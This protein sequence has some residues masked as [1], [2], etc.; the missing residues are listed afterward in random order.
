[1]VARAPIPPSTRSLPAPRTSAS[2]TD[3]PPPSSRHVT[4]AGGLRRVLAA[5]VSVTLGA[6]IAQ[7][8]DEWHP[9]SWPV[10][11]THCM[12]P[13]SDRTTAFRSTVVYNLGQ[14]G[15]D[16]RW[17][18]RTAIPTLAAFDPVRAFA[19]RGGLSIEAWLFNDSALGPLEA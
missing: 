8:A 19:T 13:P 6:L 4:Q 12:P 3:L 11:Q 10:G 5:L 7:S 16:P 14:A 15:A 9:D 18:C 2:P 17:N 1:M